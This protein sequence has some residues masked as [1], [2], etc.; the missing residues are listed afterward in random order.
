[1]KCVNDLSIDQKA[2]LTE[3]CPSRRLS[4]KTLAKVLVDPVRI[5]DVL[6][7]LDDLGWLNSSVS[8]S[9][10]HAVVTVQYYLTVEARDYVLSMPLAATTGFQ[11]DENL[12]HI[13]TMWSVPSRVRRFAYEMRGVRS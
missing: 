9:K 2:V 5:A 11:L 1:M 6:D 13:N 12:V 4:A 10:R 3:L 8:R 7:S